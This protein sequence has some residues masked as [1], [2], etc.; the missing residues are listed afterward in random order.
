MLNLISGWY[1]VL[2]CLSGMILANGFSA[3][4]EPVALEI[5]QQVDRQRLPQ[6]GFQA[7]M[8]ITPY[9]DGIAQEPGLYTVRSN[10]ENFVLVEAKNPDQRGQKFLTTESG[11]FFFAP[12]TKRAIRMTP[13][14]TL[15]G[16][17]SIGDIS[18]LHFVSDYVADMPANLQSACVE[19]GCQ[20]LELRSKNETATYARI[21]LQ[22]KKI[23]NSFAPAHAALYL[24]SGKL[25]KTVE[26]GKSENAL[27][28]PARY[29]DAINTRLETRVE[30]LSMKPA[31]FPASMFN[32]RALEQ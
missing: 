31:T 23:A 15:R 28:A 10:G 1:R 24:V 8:R 18:R 12:R 25:S 29:I 20:I 11:I 27:P 6:G 2:C 13:L 4:A 7:E 19:I 32:P 3:A 21:V 30:Y 22:V 26:Y 9:K 16:Q 5:L 14:Q 17:A